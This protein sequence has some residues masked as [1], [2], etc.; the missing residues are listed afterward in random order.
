VLGRPAIADRVGRFG[1]VSSSHG[2][3]IGTVY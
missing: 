3:A 1:H 2:T